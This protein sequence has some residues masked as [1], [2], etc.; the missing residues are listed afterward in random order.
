ML[1]LFAPY[2]NDDGVV[3]RLTQYKNLNYT[4]EIAYWQ[5]YHNREDLLELIEKDF[6][7]NQIIENYASGRIDSLKRK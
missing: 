5:W 7:T 4:E 3:K 1:E 6:E 2:L